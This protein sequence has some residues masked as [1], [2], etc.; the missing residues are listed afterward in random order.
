METK[1]IITIL[2]ADDQPIARAG[3]RQ[4]LSKAK[5]FEI[6]GEARDGFETLKRVSQLRPRVLLLDIKMPGPRS[7]EI[8]KWIRENFPETV[9]LV[10]TSHDHDA[11]LASM[12]DAG[13]VGYLTKEESAN[14]LINAIRQ[15]A[16]GIIYF[17]EE[18]IDRMQ[19]WKHEVKEKWEKLSIREREVLRILKLG[20]DNK[21]IAESLSVS[22]KTVEFHMTNILKKLTLNSRDEAIVWMHENSVGDL[23]IS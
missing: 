20:K 11:Y 1:N 3:I 5:D 2:I 21:T 12:I 19:R 14:R 23:D 6:V 4:L 15:A 8:E 16:I 10:L 13:A 17:N 18:Q 9:T 7:F 22:I